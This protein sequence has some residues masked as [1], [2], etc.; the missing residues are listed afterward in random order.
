MDLNDLNEDTINAKVLDSL[1]VTMGNFRFALGIS[2]LS[3]LRETVVELPTITWDDIGGLDKV[4][5]ELQ[6][7]VRYPVD[8]PVKFIEYGM[9]TCRKVVLF[10][11]GK[12]FLSCF[13]SVTDRYIRAPSF[14]RCGSVNIRDVFHKAR[15]AAPC[16][17]FFDELDSIAEARG[18]GGGDARGAGDRVLNQIPLSDEPSHLPIFRAALNKSPVSADIKLAA[19]VNNTHGFRGADLTFARELRSWRFVRVSTRIFETSEKGRL[20]K[21]PLVMIPGEDIEEEDLVPEI[22]L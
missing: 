3:A 7:T 13:M 6:E 9:S 1:G 20:K 14:S 4:K 10:Y 8:H 12:S 15:A 19:L 11:V 21:R 18:G 2:N 5:L 17:M 22:N 16:V